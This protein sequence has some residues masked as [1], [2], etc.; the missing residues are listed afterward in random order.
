M[1]RAKDITLVETEQLSDSFPAFNWKQLYGVQCKLTESERI[2]ILSSIEYGVKAQLRSYQQEG[3]LWLAEMRKNNHGCLLADEM[4][5]GKTL[6]VLSHLYSLGDQEGKP[7]L[8]IAPTSL[9]YNWQNELAK[10][11]PSNFINLMLISG[12]L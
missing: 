6:Q 1:F 11:I 4:G 2:A 12:Y 8:V 10:F 9:V 3:V 7:H 5:L